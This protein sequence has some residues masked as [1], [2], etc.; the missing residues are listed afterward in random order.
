MQQVEPRR[1]HVIAYASRTLNAAESNYSITH[2]EMLIVV[3]S[4]RRFR[5]IIYGY[6]IT[7]YIDHSAATRLFKGK[8]LLGRLP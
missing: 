2:M 1:P 3:W 5:D 7:V 6:D 8:N 4:L